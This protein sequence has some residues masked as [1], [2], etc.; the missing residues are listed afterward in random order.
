[1]YIN[2]SPFPDLESVHRVG[3]REFIKLWKVSYYVVW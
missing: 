2:K 1:M 3:M